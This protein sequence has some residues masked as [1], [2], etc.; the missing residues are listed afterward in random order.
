MIG[1]L[2]V[3]ALVFFLTLF[4]AC[5]PF[6]ALFPFALGALACSGGSRPCPPPLFPLA[7]RLAPLPAVP[8]AC[9]VCLRSLLVS[10]S[11]PPSLLSWP[12]VPPR[13]PAVRCS[14]PLRSGCAGLLWGLPPLSAALVPA[15]LSLGA[16]SCGSSCLLCLPP[17][18]ACFAFSSS[19][20]F[21]G[22]LGRMIC[23]L[24]YGNLKCSRWKYVVSC[25]PAAAL[26]RAGRQKTFP[27]HCDDKGMPLSQIAH[28][29]PLV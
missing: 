4:L 13:L 18:F 14:F 8:F 6:V 25:G 29:A 12:L 26:G 20:L 1:A 17:V 10:L 23:C 3:S 5:L 7:S 16:P 24:P 21:R 22:R 15:R 27:V 19:L 9:L 28:V 11:R 2:R